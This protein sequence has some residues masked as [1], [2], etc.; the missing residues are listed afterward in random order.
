MEGWTSTLK[1]PSSFVLDASIIFRSCQ[2]FA[3][4]QSTRNNTKRRALDRDHCSISVALLTRVNSNGLGTRDRSRS[5]EDVGLRTLDHA[6]QVGESFVFL[7]RGFLFFALFSRETVNLVLAAVKK[8]VYLIIYHR[9]IATICLSR[10][11]CAASFVASKTTHH[12]NVYSIRHSNVVVLG[13][14]RDTQ[15][16]CR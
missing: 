15:F 4:L 3:W 12:G 6:R 8:A 11:V 5:S 10:T 7:R 16:S 2:Y 14:S 9:R 1:S 13:R